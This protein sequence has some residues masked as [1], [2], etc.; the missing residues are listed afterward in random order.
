MAN[1]A[2]TQP[3]ETNT[4]ANVEGPSALDNLQVTYENNKKRIN[5][6]ITVVLGAIVAFFAYQ[7]LYKAPREE[8]AATAVAF[9][10]RYFEV[11]SVG[12]ALNGDGQHQGFL[13]IMK[14]YSGTATANLC[15]YYAGVCYLKM[16]D[17]KN[18]V[19]YLEDFD[20]H[21]TKVAFASY[22]A[23][24]DAYM[25]TGNKKKAIDYYEKASSDKDND[26]FTPLYLERLGIVYEMVNKKKKKKKAYKRVRDEY[27]M[28]MQA[29]NM[30][31][32]LARLGD[33]E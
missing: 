22:G 10:Q 20:A 13:K 14:K 11:D 17:F 5:T 18:A 16:G 4:N 1:S 21:G 28:S 6:V 26:A 12:R 3:G 33:V 15:N 23:L 8:K 2:R 24:G 25:E 32:N 19:K 30:D 29:R 31:K 9:A 7:K 27:P